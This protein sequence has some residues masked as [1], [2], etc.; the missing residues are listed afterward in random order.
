MR[1]R[2]NEL[3][4]PSG[5]SYAAMNRIVEDRMS[6]DK[7]YREQ[8]RSSGRPVLSHGR[9]MANEEL[10]AKLSSF[11]LD[12]DVEIVKELAARF[13]SAQELSEFLLERSGP[14]RFPRSFD[15]D[16]VWI[17]AAVV[18]ERCLPN[19]PSMEMIDDGMQDGYHKVDSE[20]SAAACQV[21]LPVWRDIARI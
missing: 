15:E 6:S 5:M 14:L 21:W 10:F 1:H 7:D 16:W 19:R 20:G 17:A 9:K 8:L 3:E 12:I 2:T 13:L 4:K 18:W 11:G